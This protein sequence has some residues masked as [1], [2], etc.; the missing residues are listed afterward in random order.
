MTE[1]GSFDVSASDQRI[2]LQPNMSRPNNGTRMKISPSG[3]YVSSISSGNQDAGDALTNNK[4]NNSGG[5][6]RCTTSCYSQLTPA[7]GEAYLQASREY[8]RIRKSQGAICSGAQHI[9]DVEIVSKEYRTGH[10]FLKLQ[11]NTNPQHEDLIYLPGDPFPAIRGNC[12]T[13]LH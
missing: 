1:V 4:N 10:T 13:T 9:S 11:D 2:P 6:L 8:K 7:Q 5:Q 12:S 3:V